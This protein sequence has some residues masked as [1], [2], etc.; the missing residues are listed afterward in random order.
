MVFNYSRVGRYDDA[1]EDLFDLDDQ[2][3]SSSPPS[4]VE[5]IGY[6]QKKIVRIA[7]ALISEADVQMLAMKNHW[8]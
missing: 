3:L 7:A 1:L 2:L 6:R 8:R 4:M 5:V